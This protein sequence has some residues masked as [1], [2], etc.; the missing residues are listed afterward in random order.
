MYVSKLKIVELECAE[1]HTL[2]NVKIAGRTVRS[3]VDTGASH[4]CLDV[5]FAKEILPDLIT[6][7]HEGVTAGIGGNDFDV[8]IADIPDFRIG[9]FRLKT[10]HNMALLD[11]TYLNEA[12]KR[13]NQKPIQMILGNDF[14]V[15]HKVVIDYCDKVLY[16]E[17]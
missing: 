8:K 15:A 17:N 9:R 14:L 1:F 12:Y 10:Y 2:L 6:S 3:V 4:S 11:F 7:D 16:F 5:E 13:L